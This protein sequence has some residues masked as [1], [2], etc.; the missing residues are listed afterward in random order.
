MQSVSSKSPLSTRSEPE[1]RIRREQGITVG[2]FEKAVLDELMKSPPDDERDG[3][4]ASSI[5]DG[6]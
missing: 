3:I 4:V 6:R 1:N 5:S 2:A